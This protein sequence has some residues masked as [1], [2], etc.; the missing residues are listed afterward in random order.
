M[1]HSQPLD[2]AQPNNRHQNPGQIA[3]AVPQRGIHPPA[4]QPQ[5]RLVWPG[6]DLIHDR[7]GDFTFHPGPDER[8]SRLVECLICE[9]ESTPDQLYCLPCNHWHCQDCLKENVRI[10]F[11]SN[12][13]QP[14]KCCNVLP[15]EALQKYGVITHEEAQRYIKKIQELTT[16]HSKLYCW[17][18]DCGAFIPLE[19]R[20]KKIGACTQCGRNTCKNCLAKSHFGPC[21]TARLQSLEES[22]DKL[23]MLAE[24]KGWKRCPKCTSLI[25][26]HGGCNHMSCHCGQQFC[27]KCGQPFGRTFHNCL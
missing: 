7:A 26:K 12:P 24:Q 25:Q 3:G 1:D 17:G 6:A 13:F 2:A 9:K 16:P 22:E 5:R 27:Y 20:R 4:N 21:D 19:N 18:G 11:A 10:S 8:G 15:E 23:C 14:A